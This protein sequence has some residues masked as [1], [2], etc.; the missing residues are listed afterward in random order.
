MWPAPWHAQPKPSFP[1]HPIQ[2]PVD[3]WIGVLY[4]IPS[5]RNFA[6]R[7]TSE[8]RSAIRS[9][10]VCCSFS[11]ILKVFGIRSSKPL[12]CPSDHSAILALSMAVTKLFDS[13]MCHLSRSSR[14]PQL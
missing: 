4:L 14:Q 7:L 5:P 3:G 8:S 10:Y 9:P 1:L 2:L 13:W 12:R 6:W 11:A